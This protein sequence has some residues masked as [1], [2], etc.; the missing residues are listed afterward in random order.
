MDTQVV[1]VGG[2]PAAHNAGLVFGRSSVRTLICDEGCPRN[3]VAKHSHSLFTRDGTPP[4]EL[5]EIAI[6]QL[7]QYDTMTFVRDR[8]VEIEKISGGFRVSLD[9]GDPVT[10]DLVLLAL[11]V[12][13]R[14]PDIP[15][16]DALWGDT[17]IHCPYCHGWEVRDLPWAAYVTSPQH[18]PV[19]AKLRSWSDDVVVIVDRG[20][21]LT[22]DQ[23]QQLAAAGYPIEHGTIRALHAT[24]GRLDSI[25]LDGGRRMSR[26]VLLYSPP[27]KQ[28][29]LVEAL[30]LK[31]DEG[32]Y[33]VTDEAGQTSM[34]GV[35]AAGDLI[36]PRQQIVIAA[37]NGALT[38]IAIHG[39][40]SAS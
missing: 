33:V 38:A 28:T 5:R 17:V 12:E 30:G 13:D 14:H 2:G 3:R 10:T 8:V 39:V 25:E 36:T 21:S 40:L 32:G 29:A 11:G 23:Q 27:Q 16:F 35:Y 1:I 20:L 15:G 7:A 26:K 9:E 4:L 18:I 37:A 31:L 22:P 34:K 19:I 6:E 24:D